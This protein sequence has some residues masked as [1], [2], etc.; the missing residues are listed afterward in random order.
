MAILTRKYFNGIEILRVNS[1]PDGVSSPVGSLAVDVLTNTKYRSQGGGT[2]SIIN[3]SEITLNSPIRAHSNNHVR[4]TSDELNAD[5]LDIDFVPT[6]Y[7]RTSS[8]TGV[9]N[10]NSVEHLTAHLKGIDNALQG[11]QGGVQGAQGTQGAQGATGDRGTQGVQG[12]QGATGTGTQG[13]QGVQGAQGAQGASGGGGGGGDSSLPIINVVT[14]YA[15]WGGVSGAVPDV[16]SGGDVIQDAIDFFIE[17]YEDYHAVY[18]PPG[19]YYISQPL[20]IAKSNSFVACTIMSSE[21]NFPIAGGVGGAVIRWNVGNGISPSPGLEDPML[22][23]QGARRVSLRGINFEGVNTAPATLINDA[24]DETRHYRCLFVSEYAEWVSAGIRENLYS[25]QCCVAI[26]PFINGNPGGNSN[27]RYPNL[28]SYYTSAYANSSSNIV[29][30]YCSFNKSNF[31]VVISPGEVMQNAENFLFSKCHWNYNRVHY[32]TGQSQARQNTLFCPAMYGSYIAIDNLLA[33]PGSSIGTP[34]VFAGGINIGGTKYVFNLETTSQLLRVD[35]LYAESVASLGR[36]GLGSSA[37]KGTLFTGCDITFI[38]P[39]EAGKGGSLKGTAASVP[40]HLWTTALA[41]FDQCAFQYSDDPLKL[42]TGNPGRLKFTQCSFLGVGYNNKVQV[43]FDKHGARITG[44]NLV[45]FD[46]SMGRISNTSVAYHDEP[47]NNNWSS[48]DLGNVTVTRDATYLTTGSFSVSNASAANLTVGDLLI[49][50]SSATSVNPEILA[51]PEY[52]F[53]SSDLWSTF[54][55]IRS[56]TAGPTNSTVTF[57]GLF[58]GFP[59]GIEANVYRFR[60]Q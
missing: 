34:P 43:G 38:V 27:N 21:T 16:S 41:H 26:D 31:G 48:V 2:W 19:V 4:G 49:L 3:L 18:I 30:E 57:S 36:I 59:T 47:H 25:P 53:S 58:D 22:V 17:N 52:G 8:G 60:W 10:V 54:G 5:L 11:V 14:D 7:T 13:T 44:A 45:R 37:G 23:I 33:G 28:T 29:F 55:S 35:N 1:A 12:A 39:S 24:V 42:V 51:A 40:F 32:S 20:I 46:T 56:I 15:I 9:A 50:N 6:S